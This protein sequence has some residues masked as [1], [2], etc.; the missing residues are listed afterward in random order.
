M[1]GTGRS[2]KDSATEM[3]AILQKWQ[4]QK[5]RGADALLR[6]TGHLKSIQ[7]STSEPPHIVKEV[8]K[9]APSLRLDAYLKSGWLIDGGQGWEQAQSLQ[10]QYLRLQHVHA[11]SGSLL[12]RLQALVEQ[13]QQQWEAAPEFQPTWGRPDS[14]MDTSTHTGMHSAISSENTQ[15]EDHS[16]AVVDVTSTN[17]SE[18]CSGSDILFM[19]VSLL[20]G[21]EKE[22]QI[23]DR[24]CP[25]IQLDTPVDELDIYCTVWQLQPYLDEDLLADFLNRF[26]SR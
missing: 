15:G 17:R 10:D 14:G 12:S 19:M 16:T 23:M 11:A 18:E 7:S 22:L 2:L 20:D 21:L 4:E 3:C 13:A 24:V 5:A 25:S 8:A 26:P 9:Q 6:I 1:D